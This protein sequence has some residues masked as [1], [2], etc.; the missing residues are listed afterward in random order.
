MET[1]FQYGS[2]REDGGCQPVGGSSLDTPVR[3]SQVK[4]GGAKIGRLYTE[5]QCFQMESSTLLLRSYS[6][7]EQ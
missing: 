7:C 2:E 3:V 6:G 5:P 1:V 4:Q